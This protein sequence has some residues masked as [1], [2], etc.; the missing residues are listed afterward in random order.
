MVEHYYQVKGLTVNLYYKIDL[1]NYI[2][3]LE[4]N[5]NEVIKKNN[6]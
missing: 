6:K 4:Q 3:L 5:L 2:I 1:I